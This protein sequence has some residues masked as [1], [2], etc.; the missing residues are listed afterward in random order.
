[1]YLSYEIIVLEGWSVYCVGWIGRRIY[2]NVN[3]NTILPTDETDTNAEILT[4][5]P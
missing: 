3:D 4:I 5:K 2:D 1:M